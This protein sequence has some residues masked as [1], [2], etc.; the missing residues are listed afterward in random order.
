MDRKGFGIELGAPLV[1]A[2]AIMAIAAAGPQRATDADRAAELVVRWQQIIYP[3]FE[4]ARAYISEE[5]SDQVNALLSQ[6][7]VKAVRDRVDAPGLR[8]V[9]NAVE[10]FAAAMIKAGARQPNGSLIL[11][12]DA[13]GKALDALCPLYPFCEH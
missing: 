12:A 11:E 2:A 13:Y 1:I 5:N 3:R 9:D 10:R 6:G 8:K 4:D 7:A